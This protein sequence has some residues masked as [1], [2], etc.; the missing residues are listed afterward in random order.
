MLRGTAVIGLSDLVGK[1]QAMAKE[2]SGEARSELA[3]RGA[4]V[5]V[6]SV[7]QKIVQQGL[8]LEGELLNSVI[9]TKIN[10]WTAG[11]EV[12]MP[13][14]AVHEYGLR[15]HVITDRQR[16]FFWT[17]Y[18]GTGDKMWKCLAL[19]TTYTIPARPY[20]RPGIDDG[21][22][23]AAVAMADALLDLLA[24]YGEK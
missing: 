4:E 6:D 13:Y 2:L 8:V 17:M 5:I 16:A 11:A 22:R 1:F 7:K 19:S 3:L 9:A 18:G 12:N 24:K 15:D 20:F 10:Q 14:A 23:K 21:K